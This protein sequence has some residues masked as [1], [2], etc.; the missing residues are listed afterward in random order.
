M[1]RRKDGL[2][3]VQVEGE[4]HQFQMEKQ[5]WKEERQSPLHTDPWP[6]GWKITFFQKTYRRMIKISV[7]VIVKW[8]SFE[9]QVSWGFLRLTKRQKKTKK[10]GSDIYTAWW[11]T[12]DFSSRYSDICAPTTVPPQVNFISRYL[13]KRLEL[14]LMAVQAFPKASTRLLTSR[15][16]SWS[17]RLLAWIKHYSS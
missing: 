17:V 3:E 2:T 9:C 12:R 10:E 13:P 1:I 14:S 16:F 6:A 15:I 4:C 5:R 7:D 11:M 8:R